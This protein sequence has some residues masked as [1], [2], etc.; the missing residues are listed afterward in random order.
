MS[1]EEAEKML[2]EKTLAENDGN[3]TKSAEVLGVTRK[4]LRNKK[5]KY[6]L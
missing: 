6:G 2:I 1:L 3:I 4:T 5:D